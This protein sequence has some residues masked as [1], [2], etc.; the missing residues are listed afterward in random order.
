MIQRGMK[1]MSESS[2]VTITYTFDAPRDKVYEAWTDPKH[3]THWWGSKGF[4]SPLDKIS[5]DVRPGGEWRAPI[6]SDDG[7]EIPFSGTYR[8]V[9][10]PNKLAFTVTDPAEDQ[11]TA[12]VIALIFNDLGDGRTELA[13]NQAGEMTEEGLAELT[14]GWGQFFDKLNEYL[15]K[16]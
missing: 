4:S 2:G 9:D 5:L 16:S 15:T 11:E 1:R 12:D 3:F 10:K 14:A 7:M 8:V 13:F 6:F